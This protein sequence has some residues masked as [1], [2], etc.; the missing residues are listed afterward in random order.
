[1]L[2]RTPLSLAH[3]ARSPKV[4]LVRRSDDETT[5]DSHSAPLTVRHGLIAWANLEPVVPVDSP[6]RRAR[7]GVEGRFAI[8]WLIRRWEEGAQADGWNDLIQ[9]GRLARQITM[10]AMDLGIASRVVL[11]DDERPVLAALGL[12]RGLVH[13]LV[14]GRPSR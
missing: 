6:A 9:V 13:T 10:N 11:V 2:R 4:A 1:M 8:V 3:T 5:A 7:G 12:A 14:L